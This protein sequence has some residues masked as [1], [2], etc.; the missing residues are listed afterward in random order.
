[1]RRSAAYLAL[2]A[3]LLQVIAVA[4]C[5]CGLAS[6]AAHAQAAMPHCHE[7]ASDTPSDHRQSDDPAQGQHSHCPFFF[8]AH[9]HAP[10]AVAPS[11]ASLEV[12]FAV[13]VT[14]EQAAFIFPSPA[15]FPAG[16]PP[17]GPPADA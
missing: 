9:C 15:H 16:A 3:L 7:V 10:L 8:S 12:F 4:L 14:P 2:L 5:P 1:M 11:I 13:S 17:R 6:A